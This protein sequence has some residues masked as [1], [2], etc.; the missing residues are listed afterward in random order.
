MTPVKQEFTHK[1]EIGQ[2]GDCQRAVIASLLDLPIADVPHFLQEADGDATKFWEGMQ[3]FLHSK[4]Y[5][6]LTIPNACGA[7][8]Y[9]ANDDLIYYEVSGVSPRNPNVM[10]AVIGCDGEIVFDP[11]P[12]NTGLV[13]DPSKWT[14]SYIVKTCQVEQTK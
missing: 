11:H 2:H 3:S 10:H 6:Y 12:D 9:G 5:A 4:G 1:P 8:F 13:G 7:A 14:Y